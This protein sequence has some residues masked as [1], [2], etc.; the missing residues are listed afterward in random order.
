MIA[1]TLMAVVI[2][3][4]SPPDPEDIHARDKRTSD[5]G[6]MLIPDCIRDKGRV[7]QSHKVCGQGCASRYLH[8]LF[9][10]GHK[11]NVVPGPDP[12]RTGWVC[13]LELTLP[14]QRKETCPLV[15]VGASGEG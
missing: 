3:V 7:D 12:V 15:K 5:P 14:L 8:T 4:G 2:V 11:E 6:S 1:A 13:G 10:L 9:G